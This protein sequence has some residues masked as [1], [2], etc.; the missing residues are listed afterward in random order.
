M[1]KL[2]PGTK[3]PSIGNHTMKIEITDKRTDKKAYDEYIIDCY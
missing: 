2:G 3:D 1:G